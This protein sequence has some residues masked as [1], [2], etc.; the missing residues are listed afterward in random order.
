MEENNPFDQHLISLVRKPASAVQEGYLG[1]ITSRKQGERVRAQYQALNDLTRKVNLES[2]RDMPSNDTDRINWVRRIFE[3]I[4]DF[5][6]VNARVNGQDQEVSLPPDGN[7]PEPQTTPGGA[8]GSSTTV[9]YVEG[10]PLAPEVDNRSPN[11]HEVPN[12]SVMLQSADQD[13]GAQD[14]CQTKY[15]GQTQDAENQDEKTK[16]PGY[17]EQE[18]TVYNL[19]SIEVELIAYEILAL[20]EDAHQGNI[21]YGPWTFNKWKGTSSSMGV[22][23]IDIRYPS[24][25]ARMNIILEALR[26]QK[27]VT[28]KF[29]TADAK[30]R[31]V[32]A[33]QHE[34]SKNIN[35]VKG[36]A[37]KG[38]QL[39]KVRQLEEGDTQAM[40]P[41]ETSRSTSQAYTSYQQRKTSG[42]IRST[43]SRSA[44]P[45]VR[46]RETS[47]RNDTGKPP[48]YLTPAGPNPFISTYASPMPEIQGN[49]PFS[50][51]ASA[52]S[53]QYLYEGM[54]A[55]SPPESHNQGQPFSNPFS[56]L[57]VY[58]P[59]SA[60][61]P[62]SDVSMSGSEIFGP[63][64]QEAQR[65]AQ[66]ELAQRVAMTR[67]TIASG[68]YRP[69]D[70]SRL[71]RSDV[72]GNSN[73]NPAPPTSGAIS[74]RSASG[75]FTGLR[76]MSGQRNNAPPALN[77]HSESVPAA[78]YARAFSGASA[79]TTTRPASGAVTPGAAS[80][81][82][83]V[84][85]VF[86]HPGFASG[87]SAGS[88]R[89]VSGTS[90]ARVSPADPGAY[91]APSSMSSIRTSTASAAPESRPPLTAA[92]R[93]FTPPEA[94]LTSAASGEKEGKERGRARVESKS[95][96]EGVAPDKKKVRPEEETEAAPE[97]RQEKP[98]EEEEVE[99]VFIKQESLNLKGR[100][101]G[102]E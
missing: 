67:E 57:D 91:I 68:L 23:Y 9:Q 64:R 16:K 38:Q 45:N 39:K 11:D 81:S 20:V 75:A 78:A 85:P 24:F 28:H 65:L 12:G 83:S 74:G 61:S 89:T 8:T 13:E 95:P 34:I 49:S 55:I 70:S 22:S 80:A 41:P 33:P 62:G 96:P 44:T 19:K 2:L 66:A 26:Q 58:Y 42:Q 56:P 63:Q 69:A 25:E 99:V 82:E 97:M 43:S 90:A 92:T 17:K 37:K 14:P 15:T 18:N 30:M 27:S 52:S 6:S 31:F 102:A 29:I 88:G 10:S 94:M 53:E 98:E 1:Y 47:N 36:N 76:S 51:Y 101:E 87:P 54:P 72:E 93:M 7:P 71:T 79:A 73:V 84:S 5:T 4:T 21:H 86:V 35:N 40:P 50:G 46:S 59:L 77:L 48:S 32:A 60:S 3:A 100:W